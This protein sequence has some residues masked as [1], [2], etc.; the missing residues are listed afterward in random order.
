M[1]PDSI[2]ESVINRYKNYKV[3]DR[4]LLLQYFIDNKLKALIENIND[5]LKTY[6]WRKKWLKENP[7]LISPKAMEAM[8]RTAGCW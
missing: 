4:S 6:I 3:N 8:A 1:I 7:N 5:F 2:S